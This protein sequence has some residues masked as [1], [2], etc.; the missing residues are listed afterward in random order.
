MKVQ[1]KEFMSYPVVTIT[2][3]SDVGYARELM[4]RKGVS[5]LPVVEMKADNL[6]IC[7]IVTLFDLVGCPD[8]HISITEVMTPDIRSVSPQTSASEAATLLLEHG[9]HHLVVLDKGQITGMVSSMDFVR[10]L[11]DKKMRSFASVIFV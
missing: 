1:V 8:E 7:G 4:E 11:S 9:I 10:L 2:T 5:A 3:D 6:R